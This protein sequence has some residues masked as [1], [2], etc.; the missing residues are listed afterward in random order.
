METN[1]T[2]RN[3]HLR[4]KNHVQHESSW[5]NTATTFRQNQDQRRRLKSRHIRIR[6][7]TLLQCS[8]FYKSRTIGGMDMR[9]LNSV[10]RSRTKL[11]PRQN[12]VKK[13]GKNNNV[14]SS[15]PCP[16]WNLEATTVLA[17]TSC[18]Q[19]GQTFGVI[20]VKRRPFGVQTDHR[21]Q[22]R[23][24]LDYGPSSLAPPLSAR[25]RQRPAR[26]PRHITAT[27]YRNLRYSE[28]CPTKGRPGP[29]DGTD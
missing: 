9:F 17:P 8:Y 29:S 5:V 12:L 7:G 14:L 23:G 13:R 24:E 21:R 20:R 27:D 19:E 3:Q 22:L 26:A 11:M 2:S 10:K 18:S 1:V 28:G 4:A 16:G 15:W 25:A 6:H